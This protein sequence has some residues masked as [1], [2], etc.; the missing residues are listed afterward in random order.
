[1]AEG[2]PRAVIRAL[3]APT[4]VLSWLMVS[5]IF[6]LSGAFGSSDVLAVPQRLAFW[7]FIVGIGLGCGVTLRVT[8]QAVGRIRSYL[9]A[10]FLAA[11]LSGLVLAAVLPRLVVEILGGPLAR[12][13]GY[14]NTA[15]LIAV[16]GI[17]VALLRH[18]LTREVASAPAVAAGPPR[19]LA[20]LPEEAEGPI[21]HLSV[22]DHYVEVAT[23]RGT[24]RLLMRFSDALHEI[25]GLPGARVHR[26]HW[27]ARDA[28][29]EVRRG[30][31]RTLLVL[32]NGTEVPVSR[33]YL[34]AVET[35]W[36][37]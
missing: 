27:V 6:T 23:E 13:P 5:A 22:N 8:L 28:V 20:R 35:F 37:D 4:P 24:A 33:A 10:S 12:M 17:G 31:G 25:E 19:L 14:A 7:L 26:S 21:L 1:M 16:L 3:V 15:L 11:V 36:G 34:D 18:F 29:V 9:A 2:Y 30:G 32:S